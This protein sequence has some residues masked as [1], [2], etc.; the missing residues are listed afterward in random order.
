M[1]I[2]RSLADYFWGIP[3]DLEPE[4]YPSFGFTISK[5]EGKLVVG[6]LMPGS[7]G[8]TAGLKNG[9]RIISLDGEPISDVT[10]L[11]ILMSAKQWGDTAVLLIERGGETIP[12]EIAIEP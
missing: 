5:R 11:R 7:L 10:S 9:D 2:V 1:K 6:M 3:F 8:A 12:V 4:H